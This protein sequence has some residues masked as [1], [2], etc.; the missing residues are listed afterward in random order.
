MKRIDKITAYVSDLFNR[1]CMNDYG[2]FRDFD[3]DTDK[4]IEVP[5]FPFEKIDQDTINRI[6]ISFG[7]TPEEI[8]NMDSN[9][10]VRYWNKYPFFRLYKQYLHLW[11][12]NQHY[13]DPE[14]TAEEVLLN[15]I[16][17]DNRGI[18]VRY[19]YNIQSIKQRLIEQLKE[20]NHVMP[21]V[22][23]QGAEI[24]DLRISTQTMFSF[25]ECSSMIRS[26]LDMVERLQDLFYK[27]IDKEL[28][29]DEAGEM[30]F[31]ASWL[32]AFDK[33]TTDTLITYNNVRCYRNVYK[34]ENLKDFFEYVTI[35]AFVDDCPWRCQEFFDDTA[36]LQRFVIVFP[37]AK[38][39]MR[40]FG[41]E[42]TNFSCD[43]VWSDAKPIRT[44]I[45]VAKN[46]SELYGW[47]NYIKTLKIACGP[48]AKGGLEVPIRLSFTLY[49]GG[50]E[51]MNKRISAR[52]GG[53]VNG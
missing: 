38:S 11:E 25:P 7:I 1:Y 50:L 13:K 32:R 29:L 46:R 16:F 23:H 35:K 17:A 22:Y 34:E 2:F 49:N 14:P 18:P 48:V 4:T 6:S 24:T 27:A 19:R 30:D 40:E 37:Q 20:Y 31:L 3:D 45:Y 47:G 42:L 9:A 53:S 41:M 15:A 33:V 21:G 44:H 39:K 36:L 26:F 51:R 5:L 8:L 10:A 43:F 12:W 52:R 28:T